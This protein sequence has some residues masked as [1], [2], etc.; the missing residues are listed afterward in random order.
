MKY[1]GLVLVAALTGV[2][3]WLVAGVW[4]ELIMASFYRENAHAQHDGIGIILLAALIL[5]GLMTY[6]Y[7][8][9]YKGQKPLTHGL[10]FGVIIGLLWVFPHELAMVGAHGGSIAYVLK[11]ALWHMVEQGIGG[12]ILAYS[13]QKWVLNE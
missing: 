2:V 12:V 11:N 1:K 7:H 9:G 8:M 6:L 3:M 10:G 4:H 5:G 13:Y